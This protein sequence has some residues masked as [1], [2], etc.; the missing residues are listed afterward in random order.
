[1]IEPRNSRRS[2]L[3]GT[4]VI[5]STLVAI[6]GCS[7]TGVPGSRLQTGRDPVPAHDAVNSSSDSPAKIRIGAASWYGPGFNGKKTAS[8]DIFDPTKLTAAHRSIPLGRRVRVTH[9][10]NGKSVEV[11]INDRGPYTEGRMID[12]SQAAANALE[13]TGKGIAKVRVEE[14]EEAVIAENVRNGNR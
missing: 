7:L 3:I 6:Q 5:L 13:M 9:L 8:G 10:A 2:G 1:M 12:L 11:L 4:T 14:L